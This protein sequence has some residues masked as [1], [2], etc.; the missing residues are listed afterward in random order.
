MILSVAPDL[1]DAG[2]HV[3]LEPLLIVVADELTDVHDGV[4][5]GGHRHVVVQVP[6]IAEELLVGLKILLKDD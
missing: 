4:E 6:V 5:H 3:V 1:L 2:F